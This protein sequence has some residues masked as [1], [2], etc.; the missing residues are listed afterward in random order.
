M[1][2]LEVEGDIEEM[3]VDDYAA[4]EETL[5]ESTLNAQVYVHALDVTFDYRTM[6]VKGG[7]KGKVVHVLIDSGSTRNF[8]DMNIA[9]KMGCRLKTIPPCSVAVANESRIQRS[10]KIKGV[11]WRMQGVEFKAD[12]LP[13]PLGGADVVLGI[14]WLITLADI[15]WNFRQLKMEFQIGGK[16]VSLRGSQPGSSKLIDIR[17][18]GKLLRKTEQLSMMVVAQVQ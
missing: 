11:A 7:T 10:F 13:M 14:Q 6:R 18:M 17:K 4:E 1:F 5:E 15:K 8:M 12:M 16:K 2:I 9:K 3:E